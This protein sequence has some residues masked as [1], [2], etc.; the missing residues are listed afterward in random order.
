MTA[1]SWA[2]AAA[3]TIAAI[4]RLQSRLVRFG[5]SAAQGDAHAT[6]SIEASRRAPVNL[7][8]ADYASPAAGQSVANAT[9]LIGVVT[10]RQHGPGFQDKY[11]HARCSA[12]AQRSSHISRNQGRERCMWNTYGGLLLG[13]QTTHRE[14]WSAVAERR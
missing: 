11:G 12:Q 8:G 13:C 4:K 6:L 5:P 7:V 14:C 2:L 9:V 3:E 1:A 10:H